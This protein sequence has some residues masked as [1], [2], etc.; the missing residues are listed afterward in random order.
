VDP[1]G[2]LRLFDYISDKDGYRIDKQREFK[3]GKPINNVVR[4]PTLGG[5]KY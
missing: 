1:N 5:K 2:I 3:V 4:I